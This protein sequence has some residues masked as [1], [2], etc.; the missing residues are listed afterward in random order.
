MAS[1]FNFYFPFANKMS[2]QSLSEKG[3]FF[4][5]KL[6]FGGQEINRIAYEFI[7]LNRVNVTSFTTLRNYTCNR[8]HRG[9]ARFGS[10]SVSA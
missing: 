10:N 4:S 8:M 3:K 5:R 7:L 2:Y 6:L 9:L 1:D